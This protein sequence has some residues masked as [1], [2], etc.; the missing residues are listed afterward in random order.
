MP[1]SHQYGSRVRNKYKICQEICSLSLKISTLERQNS[2]A[3]FSV[4]Q[5]TLY[6]VHSCAWFQ[7]CNTDHTSSTKSESHKT[8]QRKL[9]KKRGVPG[10]VHMMMAPFPFWGRVGLR[11]THRATQQHWPQPLFPTG[12]EPN[13]PE[14]QVPAE[15]SPL[16]N[17]PRMK[18]CKD[19][20]PQFDPL[21]IQ[22]LASSPEH[23]NSKM[24]WSSQRQ[25]SK[26]LV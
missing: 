13:S 5:I 11:C 17:N 2:Q 4:L 6:N 20:E 9:G 19:H 22:F 16:L 1:I 8:S 23:K 18:L 7:P 12:R 25:K 21:Y 26:F 14:A 10:E 15:P 24:E 3:K